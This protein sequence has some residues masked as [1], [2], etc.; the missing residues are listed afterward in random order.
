MRLCICVYFHTAGMLRLLLFSFKQA[1]QK[2]THQQVLHMY[3]TQADSSF[4]PSNMTSNF[5]PFL[6]I[7][8]KKL[9]VN[10]RR[11]E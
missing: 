7:L 9:L 5:T 10:E 1:D 2:A 8:E 6:N 4:D 11:P 3:K